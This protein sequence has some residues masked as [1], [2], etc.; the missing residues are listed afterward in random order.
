MAHHKRS[1][2]LAQSYLKGFADRRRVDAVWQYRKS[3]NEVRLKGIRNIAHRPY[4]FSF[5][6]P[7]GTLDHSLEEWFSAVES[8]WPSLRS[9]LESNL[10]AVNLK[11]PPRRI[12]GKVRRVI[13]QY[14]L[15]Q[16]LRVPAQMEWMKKYVDDYHPMASQLTEVHKQRLRVKG[17]AHTHDEMLYRWASLLASRDLSI[18]AAPAGSGLDVFTCDNPVIRF[19]PRGPDGI[20]YDTTHV[21]FPLSR[22]SF[23]RFFGHDVGT[24]HDR[25]LIK[26]HHDPDK[27]NDFNHVVVEQATEEVYATNPRQLCDLLHGMGHNVELRCPSGGPYR[28]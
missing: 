18:E 13:L 26:V 2:Y 1:H 5:E 21:L 27:I 20:A 25:I 11:E 12:T 17:L 10:Q 19:N 28:P 7:S 24:M 23:I 6:E 15:I 4:Y 9:A 22:R 14:M 8:S 16:Y 3:K